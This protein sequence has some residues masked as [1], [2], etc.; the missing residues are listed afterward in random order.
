MF[1]MPDHVLDYIMYLVRALPKKTTRFCEQVLQHAGRI[2]R[3]STLFGST[4][5]VIAERLL[6]FSQCPISKIKN[7]PRH[8]AKIANV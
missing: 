7:A 2:L 8:K 3:S 4:L 1:V 6:F 5:Y